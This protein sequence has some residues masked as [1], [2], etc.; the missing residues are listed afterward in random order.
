MTL[1]NLKFLGKYISQKLSQASEALLKAIVSFDPETAT[2]AQVAQMEADLDNLGQRVAEARQAHTEA[3][4]AFDQADKVNTQRLTAAGILESKINALAEGSP[5]RTSKEKSLEALVDQVEDAQEELNDLRAA[6]TETDEFATMLYDAYQ[7]AAESLQAARRRIESAARKMARTQLGAERAEQRADAA[8]VAAGVRKANPAL[9]T[10][11]AAMEQVSRDAHVRTDAAN[12]KAGAFGKG[13][14]EDPNI[15][16]AMAEASGTNTT[17][18][19]VSQRLAA[20]R[21]EKDKAA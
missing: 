17:K 4:T 7:E 3:K 11:L 16:S 10:A 1:S 6:A 15:A 21:G 8:A 5:E 2:E 13:T 18:Q 12:L 14:K 9:N 20:L 19:S